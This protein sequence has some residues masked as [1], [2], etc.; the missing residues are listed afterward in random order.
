VT[1]SLYESIEQHVREQYPQ[2][3]TVF[4][5]SEIELTT[6]FVQHQAID[7]SAM[8]PDQWERHYETIKIALKEVHIEL[9][10]GG[11]ASKHASGVSAFIRQ[12]VSI[13]LTSGGSPSGTI[14]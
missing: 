4:I 11:S 3:D 6:R 2:A 10:L 12:M 5:R 9:Q 8:P 13:I 7:V 1:V 14:N